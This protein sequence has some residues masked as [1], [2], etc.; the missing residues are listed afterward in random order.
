MKGVQVIRV[1]VCVRMQ[2]D[3]HGIVTPLAYHSGDERWVKVEEIMRDKDM[4]TS[5]HAEEM[6]SF[7]VQADRRTQ[8]LRL[9]LGTGIW[10][11]DMPIGAYAFPRDDESC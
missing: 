11:L 2:C 9:N 10:T 1:P 6:I 5:K 7:L 8:T 4:H 3:E